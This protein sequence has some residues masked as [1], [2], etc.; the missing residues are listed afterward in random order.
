MLITQHTHKLRTKLTFSDEVNFE[1]NFAWFILEIF[2]FTV[3][4]LGVLLKKNP[5]T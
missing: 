2:G 5:L 3:F 4:F 1:K